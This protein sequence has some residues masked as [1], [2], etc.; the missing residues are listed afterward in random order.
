MAQVTVEIAGRSYRLV[1]DDGEQDQIIA[2]AER[3]DGFAAGVKLNR[4][5]ANEARIVVMAALMLADQLQIAET[6]RDAIKADLKAESSNAGADDEITDLEREVI[7][8]LDR[9]SAEMDKATREIEAL[10]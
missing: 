5:P 2:L 3:L 8:M 10:S 7:D 4:T 9:A 1:C 6:E